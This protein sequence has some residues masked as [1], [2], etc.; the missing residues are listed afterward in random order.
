MRVDFY[1]LIQFRMI[2]MFSSK[3]ID[4]QVPM[5]IE[6]GVSW[7]LIRMGGRMRLSRMLRIGEEL[8]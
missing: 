4:Q 7:A 8:K 3:E 5:V 1:W 2:L 6:M